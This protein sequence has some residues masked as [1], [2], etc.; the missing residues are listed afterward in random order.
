MTFFTITI[1][2]RSVPFVLVSSVSSRSSV[3]VGP[4][5]VWVES[6]GG[7]KTGHEKQGGQTCSR[8]SPKSVLF[9]FFSFVFLFMFILLPF[10]T[11][12]TY[13]LAF[14]FYIYIFLHRGRSKAVWFGLVGMGKKKDLV[15]FGFRCIVSGLGRMERG[16]RYCLTTSA[17]DIIRLND[18]PILSVWTALQWGAGGCAMVDEMAILAGLVA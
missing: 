11:I 14:Y 6:E 10:T 1:L 12:M 17:Y 18:L 2:S 4:R 3:L 13:F 9:T 16:S 15:R 7:R 8:G 5:L